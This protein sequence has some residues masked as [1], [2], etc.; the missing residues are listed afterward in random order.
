MR[1]D[2]SQNAYHAAMNKLMDSKKYGDTLLGRAEKI[3]KLGA[4]NTK[5]LPKDLLE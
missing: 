3:R 5:K 4:K 1:I 2:Q